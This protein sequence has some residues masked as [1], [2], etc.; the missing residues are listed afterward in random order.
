MRDI[1]IA[2][3]ITYKSWIG[4]GVCEASKVDNK[5]STWNYSG[6]FDKHG[7]NLWS[8]NGYTWT[9]DSK[10]HQQSG[11]PSY[12]NG[13]VIIMKIFNKE[14]MLRMKRDTATNWECEL[15]ITLPVCFC[16]NL[17]GIGDALE[18]LPKNYK[19]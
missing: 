18:I 7:T 12:V 15:P 1:E 17:G 5:D 19:K 8:M 2:M 9:T 6:G 4:V 11:K 10:T 14:Q 13:D 3:K 16:G